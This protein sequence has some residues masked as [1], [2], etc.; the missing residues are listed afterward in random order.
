MSLNLDARPLHA[1]LDLNAVRLTTQFAELPG[2]AQ[3]WLAAALPR[4]CDALAKDGRVAHWQTALAALPPLAVARCDFGATVRADGPCDAATRAALRAALLALA[5]WRKGP[6]E[7]F[8]TLI[9]SEWRSDWK[10]ARVLPHL[11]PLAGRRVLDVGCGNGYY[12]W[13]MAE[14]GARLVLGIDPALA[15]FAQCAALSRYLHAPA[16]H[17]LPLAS[18]D[19][20]DRL[21]CFD[22]VFSMGVLYHRRDHLAHLR[23]LRRALRAG[24][25]LL[26]ETLVI[27]DGR[28][29]LLLP[30]S[31]YAAMRNVWALPSPATVASWLAQ[32]GFRAARLVDVSATTVAEQRSTAWMPYHSLADFLAPDTPALTIEGHPAPVRAVFVASAP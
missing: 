15:A 9:D 3:A 14:A 8:D 30:D 21:A 12:L 24:G 19:L 20:D 28:S 5:P 4:A 27:V 18:A 10:W 23:E 1:F 2:N 25:E 16:V 6:F 13:R 31:R 17:M 22:T 26:L 7:L 32:A 11:Q 29:E